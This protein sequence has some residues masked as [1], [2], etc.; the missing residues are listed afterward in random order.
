M[1]R[2]IGKKAL[3]LII[4]LFIM[5]IVAFF[6]IRV[7]PG[8]PI[9]LMFGERDV[10]IEL[11]QNIKSMY[12]LDKP[13]I[14]QYLI[15][16]K[17]LLR[18][19]LGYSYFYVGKH[20]NELISRS[21]MNTFKLTLVAFPVSVVLGIGLGCL[22]GYKRG[23]VLDKVV[24][25][26]T[27]LMTAIPDVPLAIFLVF[28]FSIKL[29]MFPIAGWGKP[30]YFILPAIFISI[31]PSL[32]LAKMVRS[33]IIEEMS[34][35]YVYMCRT[36]G[37]SDARIILKEIMPNILIPVTTSMGIMFGRML[38]GA[39]IA[40]Q[41]FNIPGLGRTAVDAIFRRDYPVIMAI[42]LLTT[43]IYTSINFI[44]DISHYILDP[45]L[46]GKNNEIT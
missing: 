9:D 39:F 3:N 27:G 8:D 14:Q 6:A 12:N 21:F 31:W 29:K 46:R 5:S 40:E 43:F 26:F 37:L 42:I 7:M 38:E 10:S 1:I 19:D 33:L 16:F 45:R 17:D 41:V 44:I 18:L 34:K 15:F 13:I 11:M 4:V 28:I 32:S 25:F 24:N 2:N 36:R 23:K 35:P 30:K 22:T 20:V